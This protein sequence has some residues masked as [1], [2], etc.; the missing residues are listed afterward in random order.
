MR[1]EDK[2]CECEK[3]RVVSEGREWLRATENKYEGKER[4]KGGV[5]EGVWI[6]CARG[7]WR[8][9]C[10]GCDVR[11]VMHPSLPNTAR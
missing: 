2:R 3:V 1:G 4:G 10:F 8:S 6:W 11:A 7:H 5:R 9:R